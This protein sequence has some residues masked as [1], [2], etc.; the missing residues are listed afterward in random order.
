MMT[1][2]I[3]IRRP[4]DW[5]VHLRDG[6]ML[7]QVVNFTAKQF[8]RA[9]IMPNLTPPVITVKRGME[10]RER[11]FKSVDPSLSFTPLMVSY[12]TD[13]IDKD[14]VKLGYNEGVFTAAKLYPAN[15]TTNSSMGVTDV[16]NI[17]PTLEVMQKIGMPLL[18]HGEVTQK[19]VDIFDREAVF[20]D[21][22]LKSL[23]K[24][25]PSLKIV[26]EHISTSE[27]A[28]F[29]LESDNNIAATITPHHLELN[30]NAIF[31]GGIRPHNYCLPIV[32]REKHRVALRKAATS[33]SPKF[34]LG[35]D[36]A[37]HSKGAKESACGCAG[38]FNAPFA[39]EA[40]TKIFD[41]ENSLDKLEAFSS[42]FGPQF[43][44]LPLNEEKVM[45]ERTNTSVPME[46]DI[47]NT[48]IVPFHS[49][50]NIPW[51]FSRL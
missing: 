39:M 35:T 17:Y 48:T 23:I 42:E 45:L 13:D 5:H 6:P 30:R 49:G 29:V 7:S 12:L 41:E 22:I 40:Y 51:K 20:I 27:A 26:F 10:Y 11:I 38:L 34:F 1:D 2:K 9:I 46:I 3:I 47:I 19:H 28:D 16:K 24:D 21:E 31:E 44:G 33:G 15:A 18:L 8:K 36:S 4:D 25:F 14:E 37:P 32:K 43:Y 50:N